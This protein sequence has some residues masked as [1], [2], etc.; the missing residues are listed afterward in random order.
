M[1][2]RIIYVRFDFK[3]GEIF[4]HGE[5]VQV[6]L[7]L[8]FGMSVGESDLKFGHIIYTCISKNNYKK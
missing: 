7:I 5:D 6:M 1:K 4:H 2:E 8:R 3:F